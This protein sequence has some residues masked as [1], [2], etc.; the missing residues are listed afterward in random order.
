LIQLKREG[1]KPARD[2]VL[3]ASGDEESQMKTTKA[4]AEQNHD[5]ELLLNVDGGGGSIGDDGKPLGYGIDGA[6]KSYADFELTFTNPGGH[7]SAPR[8]SNAIYELAHA[9]TNIGNF[10]FPGQVNDITRASLTAQA[11][12]EDDP[13]TAAAIRAFL[14]DQNDAAALAVL[15]ARPGYI[16]QIGTTCVATQLSGGHAP[17]AL[18]QRATANI[19][20]RIFPGV[21]RKDV[22]AKLAEVANDPKMTIREIEAGALDS[23]A[24]PLR[25]DVMNAVT[26]AIHARFPGVKVVPGQSSGASDSMYFRARGIPSYGISPIFMKGSDSFSHGLNERTP[27]SEIA[28]S[29]VYY[30]SV[31]K[32]L[33][34]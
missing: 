20:C 6:E 13:A 32:D 28:P 9:L 19:N 22:M 11:D 24:S 17:N 1:Y 25:P 15:R 18:P 26:K 16:G 21:D 33:A 23:P 30:K 3:L 34:K 29:I 12:S 10:Y 5:G 8:P 2:L 27:L 7:S 14:K 4:L 31:L